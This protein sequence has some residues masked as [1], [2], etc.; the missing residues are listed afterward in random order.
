V[1]RKSRNSKK[2]P[3]K[4]KAECINLAMYGKN[5]SERKKYRSRP[6]PPFPANAAGCQ[7][8]VMKGNDGNSYKSVENANGVFGWKLVK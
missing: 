6:S 3:R 5:E 4:S 1:S 2:T 7:G 8:K